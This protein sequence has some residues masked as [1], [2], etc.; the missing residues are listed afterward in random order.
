MKRISAEN[1]RKQLAPCHDKAYF[2]ASI[3]N[4][5]VLKERVGKGARGDPSS[6][7]F[8]KEQS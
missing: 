1:E 4:L 3:L 7:V 2:I 6:T 5:A 8:V